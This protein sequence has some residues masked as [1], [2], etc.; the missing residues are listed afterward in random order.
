MS[1]VSGVIIKNNKILLM[2][3]KKYGREYWV[4]P[5]GKVEPGETQEQAIAREI[6]E[7]TSLE[8]SKVFEVIT[9]FDEDKAKHFIA[10]CS[11]GKGKAMLGGPEKERNSEKNWYKPEWIDLEKAKKMKNLYPVKGKQYLLISNTRTP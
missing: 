10:I 3:R 2:H 9:Y 6:K 5:G 11:V 1:R 8:I 7:E 4:F